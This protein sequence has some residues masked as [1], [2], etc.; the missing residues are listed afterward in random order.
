MQKNMTVMV[1]VM[2]VKDN[3]KK[4]TLD[5][6]D[7]D[8]GKFLL[9]EDELVQL[10]IPKNLINLHLDEG[11]IVEIIKINDTYKITLLQGETEVAT[12][13]VSSLLEK[14]RNKK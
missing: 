12:E 9:L 1:T 2:R 10:L 14:L 13:K 7:G 3:D 4:Y 5:S 11:D 8:F 6:L